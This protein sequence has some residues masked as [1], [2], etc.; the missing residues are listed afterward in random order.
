MIYLCTYGN[1]K[2]PWTDYVVYER[3]RY[4]HVHTC[5]RACIFK[6]VFRTFVYRSPTV[7]AIPTEARYC[8][9]IAKIFS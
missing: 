7:L 8:I 3:E 4:I 6:N 5:M 9:F 2:T 1:N